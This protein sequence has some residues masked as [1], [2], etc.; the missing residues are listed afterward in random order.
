MYEQNQSGYFTIISPIWVLV[1]CIGYREA[2][3]WRPEIQPNFSGEGDDKDDNRPT[4]TLKS[5]P[6]FPLSGVSLPAIQCL[7]NHFRVV[8]DKDKEDKPQYVID[9]KQID[10]EDVKEVS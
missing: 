1:P 5:S 10:P 8:A 7:L 9:G 3:F 4:I 6:S 2:T